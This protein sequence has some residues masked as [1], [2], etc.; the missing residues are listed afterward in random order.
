MRVGQGG[1]HRRSGVRARRD[2]DALVAAVIGDPGAGLPAPSDVDFAAFWERF[3]ATAPAHLR[4]GFAT[5]VTMIS[6]IAPR[7][8]GHRGGLARLDAATASRVVERAARVPGLDALTE[9]A[10][11]VACFAYFSDPAVDALVRD[12]R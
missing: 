2:R 7:L 1:T 3:D 12:L 5:A 10:K 4:L 8:L 11:V 6:S 9:V